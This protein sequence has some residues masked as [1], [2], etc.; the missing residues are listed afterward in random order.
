MRFNF[1]VRMKFAIYPILQF[2]KTHFSNIPAF[3]L[4]EAFNLAVLSKFRDGIDREEK[5]GI[6]IYFL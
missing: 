5:Y 2:P 6:V 3:H 4:G 1:I